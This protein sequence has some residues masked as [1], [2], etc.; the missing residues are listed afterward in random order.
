MLLEGRDGLIDKSYAV[1][2]KQHALRPV[3]AHEHVD[4]GD[5]RTRLAGTGRHYQQGLALVVHL[6]SFADATDG[7]G[8][9]VAL[10]DGWVD[11][12]LGQFLAAA[13]A[14]NQQLQFVLLVE[15][16]H[17]PWRVGMVVPYPVLIPVGV[18]DDGPLA[19]HL[20]QAV[21]IQLGLLLPD[22][23]AAGGALGLHQHQRFAVVAP[24]HVVHIARVLGIGH[25]GH[26][27]F[28][29]LGWVEVPAGF[30]EQQ[31]NV[32]LA[33]FGLG[34]VVRV[35]FGGVRLLGCGHLGAQLL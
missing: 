11:D 22:L 12:S 18:E 2:K 13:A 35:R 21:G 32:G 34:I 31:V 23:G 24:E 17:G 33:G 3:A 30:A 1:G 6:K 28:E 27:D 19:V 20:L 4:Q 8:L 15:A 7:A 29:V 16:L 26:F 10:D 25:A 14:L 9:V 5:D